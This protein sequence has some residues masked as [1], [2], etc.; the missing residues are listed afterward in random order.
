[1]EKTGQIQEYGIFGIQVNLLTLKTKC[2]TLHSDY[3]HSYM[4]CVF[5]KQVYL[6]FSISK[7]CNDLML[8]LIRVGFFF[9]LILMVNS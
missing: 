2:K 8:H 9:N 1:M 6:P 5:V 3:F 7:G 4:I